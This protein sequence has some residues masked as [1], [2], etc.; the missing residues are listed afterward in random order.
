MKRKMYMDEVEIAFEELKA[1]VT[2]KK[3]HL[4]Y[5]CLYDANKLYSEGKLDLLRKFYA[6]MDVN[7]ELHINPYEPE[8]LAMI[9]ED[10]RRTVAMGIE[11]LNNKQN[12]GDRKA[13]FKV[14]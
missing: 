1:I 11:S 9:E 3:Y 10:F 14:V 6:Y 5:S 7:A 2:E 4:V 12:N 8:G 13:M